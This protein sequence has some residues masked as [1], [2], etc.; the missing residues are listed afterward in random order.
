MPAPIGNTDR[1]TGRFV[2]AAPPGA[3]LLSSADRGWRGIKVELHRFGP[4]GQAEHHVGAHRLM[5]HAGPPV[6]FERRSGGGAWTGRTLRAGDVSFLAEGTPNEPRWRDPFAFVAVGLDPAFVEGAF[7]DALPGGAAV[8][9]EPAFGRPDPVVARL[10]DLLRRELADPAFAGALF[11]ETVALALARHLLAR[12]GHGGGPRE[13]RGALSGAQLQRVVGYLHANLA[14]DVGL[15]ALAAQA[16]MSPFHFARL[17]R[18]ATGE[19]PHRFVVRLRI[20]HAQRL[21]RGRRGVT[22]TEVAAAAGF[23]DQAHFTKTFKRVVGVAPSRFA[24]A[25]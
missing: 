4:D 25:G 24:A 16:F 17:F 9:F 5:V 13:V 2:A 10:A 8:A 18:A 7:A 1:R 6:R 22:L 23:F 14:E 3:V 20:A 12:Y 21:I 11:G 19:S 15:S